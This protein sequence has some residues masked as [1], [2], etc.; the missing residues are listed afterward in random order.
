VEQLRIAHV[1]QLLWRLIRRLEET[2]R[3]AVPGGGV[4]PDF[5]FVVPGN[6][7]LLHGVFPLRLRHYT[8]HS[9][10]TCP[11][12]CGE[13]DTMVER[14]EGRYMVVAVQRLCHTAALDLL[15]LSDKHMLSETLETF[16]L[17][18]FDIRDA[19]EVLPVVG[20][21]CEVVVQGGR[22]KQDIKVRN[23]L[24]PSAEVGAYL[25]KFF[26]NRLVQGQHCE[27]SEKLTKG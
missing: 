8:D 14:R 24:S 4:N 16:G 17:V 13:S 2:L 9:P 1:L 22:A 21:Y 18:D 12:P 26:H 19:L 10:S 25:R 23:Y 20:Q 27:G 3:E 5:L 7:D 15:P 11:V 6:D